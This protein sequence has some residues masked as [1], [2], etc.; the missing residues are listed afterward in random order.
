MRTRALLLGS[1]SIVLSIVFFT[2]FRGM[3]NFLNAFLVPMTLF[4]FLKGLSYKEMVTVFMAALLVVLFLYQL[5]TIFFI[6]YGLVAV[7]LI[8]L[9]RK[10]F[11]GIFSTII[12]SLSLSFTFYLATV[13]TDYLFLTRIRAFT[14]VMLGGSPVM[15]AVYLFIFGLLVGSAMITSVRLL[16]KMNNSGRM[17]K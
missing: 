5:Q 6:F 8:K 16:S 17:L 12:I 3:S 4:V 7:L 2:V 11:N 15:Y 1:F 9:S 14:I 10:D 13:I